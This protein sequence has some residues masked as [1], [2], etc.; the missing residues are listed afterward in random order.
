MVS[1]Q[2]I[3]KGAVLAAFNDVDGDVWALL[4]GKQ[5]IV[6]GDG[7]SD[8][9]TW[10]DR[11]C[12]SQSAATYTLRV[13][14][15]DSAPDSLTAGTNYIASFNFKLADMY[16]G[17][18]ITGYSNK[19]QTRID[20]LEKKLEGRGSED[21]EPDILTAV[22]GWLNEPH[23]LQQAVGAFR[24][25]LGGGEAT[26]GAGMMHAPG[27]QAVTGF[28][29]PRSQEETTARLVKVLDR[30]ERCDPEI[31]SHLEKLAEV[32]EKK[33]DTFKFLISNLSAL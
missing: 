11:F 14:D 7:E 32:A 23:K 17:A 15:T 12:Q 5:L 16:E 31:L 13:Y 4:Q 28:T 25:L 30:L 24:M 33:P 20:D 29:L 21:E 19:L 9:I 18:G 27:Q 3:G 1:V 26:A 8:L 2:L 6:S 10:I 22:M